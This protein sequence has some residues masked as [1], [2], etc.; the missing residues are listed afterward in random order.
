[1]TIPVHRLNH[2]HLEL[3][4]RHFD[5]LS[6]DDVRLRFGNLLNLD[7]RHAYVDGI[8]FERDSVFGIYT[9]ELTLLGVAHLACVDGAA[10]L[11]I[12]VLPAYRGHGIGTALFNRAAMRAR[13]LQIVELFMHCLTQNAAIMHIARKAGMRIIVDHA[14]AD[15]YLELPPGNPLTIGQELVQQQLAQF[16][17][18]LKANVDYLRRVTRI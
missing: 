1:M 13:N 14:D 16:D 2:S 6:D 8:R 7:A 4:K 9:D 3:V 17:W 12:S 5:E 15:A 10:E 18:T 11:G